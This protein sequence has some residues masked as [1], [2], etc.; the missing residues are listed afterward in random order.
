MRL[1]PGEKIISKKPQAWE[2]YGGF[3]FFFNEGA[4]SKG[5]PYSVHFTVD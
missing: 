4:G 2:F 5:V 1:I 3:D